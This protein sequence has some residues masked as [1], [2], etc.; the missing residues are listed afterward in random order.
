MTTQ[1]EQDY[2]KA[3][4]MLQ[5][6]SAKDE[7]VNTAMIAERLNVS[8]ASASNMIKK[9]AKMG[10]LLHK[11]Y[12]GVT[13]TPEGEHI[14]LAIIRRHRLLEL[15]LSDILGYSWD[16][17]HEE[18]E[19][20]EHV[21]SDEFERRIDQAMGYPTND[22]HGAPIPDAKGVI[23]VPDYH[24]LPQLNE[25]QTGVICQ[26]SDRDSDMLRYLESLGLKPG[27]RITVEKK[28]P[29]NGPIF[30]TLESGETQILGMEVA[31]SIMI[32]STL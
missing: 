22:P 31:K 3:V 8:P 16:K 26:V 18:A 12:Q 24:P 11:P 7:A 19:Q 15:Y 29:F 1:A 13:L 28:D 6:Y 25:G 14:A 30:I 21:I 32:C 5:Q 2:L 17:V 9:L 4:Y 23:E 10:F 27:T 20:L